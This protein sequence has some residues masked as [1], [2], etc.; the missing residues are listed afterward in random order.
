MTGLTARSAIEVAGLRKSFG[1]KLVLDGIDLRVAEGRSSPCS[2][3]TAP[4]RRP[5]CRS[6]P[7]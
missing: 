3:P 2:A 6:C 4:A 5:W 7:P 1:D